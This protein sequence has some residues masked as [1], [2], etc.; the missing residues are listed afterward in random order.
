M[1][2]ERGAKDSL[3]AAAG[4]SMASATGPIATIGA[5]EGGAV[6]VVKTLNAKLLHGFDGGACLGYRQ[7][8]SISRIF[9]PKP[10]RLRCLDRGPPRPQQN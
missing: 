2:R 7:I 10:L 1:T 6:L 8:R 3:R 9:V 5:I 4:L